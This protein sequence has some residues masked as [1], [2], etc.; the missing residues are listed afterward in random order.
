M[1]PVRAGMGGGGTGEPRK[2][3]RVMADEAD[4]CLDGFWSGASAQA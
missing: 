3:A 2:I 4:M 1:L